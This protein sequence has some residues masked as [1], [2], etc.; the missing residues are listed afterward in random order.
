[1]QSNAPGEK[2]LR[3]WIKDW[4]LLRTEMLESEQLAACYMQKSWTGCSKCTVFNMSTFRC[5]QGPWGWVRV[6]VRSKAGTLNVTA[7]R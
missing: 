6:A 4:M 3:K 5:V 1:M 2:F 7:G